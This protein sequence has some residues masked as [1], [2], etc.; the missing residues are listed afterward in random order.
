MTDRAKDGDNH[1]QRLSQCTEQT[2]R[3]AEPAGRN[4]IAGRHDVILRA[5]ASWFDPRSG[6]VGARSVPNGYRLRGIMFERGAI[7]APT[8][9]LARF[10]AFMKRMI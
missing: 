9:I 2:M 7:T 3:E 8:W 1:A 4:E 10:R 6:L 5:K